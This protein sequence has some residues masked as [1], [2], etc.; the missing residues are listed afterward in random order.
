ML[1]W[2]GTE[3]V[4]RLITVHPR[5]NGGWDFG[6]QSSGRENWTDFEWSLALNPMPTGALR[7]TANFRLGKE[8]TEIPRLGLLFELRPG[9]EQLRWFGRG[10]WE[11]YPD[12]KRSAWLAVHESTVTD[13]YEPYIMPQEHGLKCDSRWVEL[14]SPEAVVR[15]S[16][17]RPFDFSASHLDAAS[18]TAAT[19]TTDVKARAETLLSIDA[20]HS[21]LGNRACGPDVL[22]EYRILGREYRLDLMMEAFLP[23]GQ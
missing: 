11:N 21:G 20:A 23:S 14:A 10:P 16:S 3:V 7:L 12:R 9:F 6:F 15:F 17:G 18:L 2:D 1:P 22:L 19:H 8:I 4:S 13:Q 5:K